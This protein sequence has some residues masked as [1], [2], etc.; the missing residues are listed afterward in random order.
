[1]RTY[2]RLTDA[3]SGVW[4]AVWNDEGVPV[5]FA[6]LVLLGIL[7]GPRAWPWLCACAA[8]ELLNTAIEVLCDFVC[9]GRHDRRIGAIKDMAAAASL[10]M[11]IAVVLRGV[12]P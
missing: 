1:M 2:E 6:L 8:V 7:L 5:L 4:Y 12:R 3:L 11:Q 9:A 10:C